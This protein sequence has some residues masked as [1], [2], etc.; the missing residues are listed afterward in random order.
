MLRSLP[1]ALLLAVANSA[2]AQYVVSA[3]AGTINF[4][5]G[6]VSVDDRPVERKPNK[7]VRLKDGQVL[8]TNRGRAEIL[9]G[10]G[11]FVRLGPHAALRMVNSRLQD[12]QIE[13][14]RG[15]ALVE[16]IEIAN[17]DDLHVLL[18]DTRTT[19]RGIGLHRFDA[20]AGELSVFGGHAQVSAGERT[21]DG[22]R[23]RII[24]LREAPTAT[25]SR[26]DPREKD[27]LLRWAAN[28]SFHLFISNPAAR[29]R[30]TNW[31]V[32]NAGGN[33]VSDQN[34]SYYFNPDFGVTFIA[35][36]PA[37]AIN[38]RPDL[39]LPSLGPR[40][41]PAPRP[42]TASQPIPAVT[43]PGPASGGPFPQ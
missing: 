37:G 1:L 12:T 11:V 26:F 4:S 14:E 13:I 8:Q 42:P 23:G 22:T 28:R 3:R 36:G 18:G 27:G 19:F 16:V 7:F 30:L 31:E 6:E 40:N 20:D 43:Y 24:H 35:R 10:P 9:L 32:T 29:A 21:F 39:L 15:V 25:E 38:V 2:W 34:R 17:G 41:D 33:P 5:T